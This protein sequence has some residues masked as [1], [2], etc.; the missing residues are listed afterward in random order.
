MKNFFDTIRRFFRRGEL[1][2]HRMVALV[3][4]A[5]LSGGFVLTSVAPVA[6]EP[7]TITIPTG[8]S[9]HE[10]GIILREAHVIRSAVLFSMLVGLSEHRTVKA[11]DYLFAR[12]ASV[13][14]VARRVSKGIFGV[15]AIRVTLPEG[16]TAAEMYDIL[17]KRLY[18]LDRETWLQATHGSEGMLFPDT[19]F[20]YPAATADHIVAMM[21]STFELKLKPLQDKIT[22][23]GRTLDDVI[24][25]ASL[26]EEEAVDPESRRLVAGILWKRLEAGMPL[27]VDAVFSYILGKNTFELSL[28]DLKVDSPYNTYTHRGLPPGPISNPGLDAIR[29]A[30]EPTPSPYWYYLTGNDGTM[31]YAK[32]FEEHKLNKKKYLTPVPSPR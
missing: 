17:A 19:Y 12:P 11:G 8:T 21:E 10:A 22:Q 7:T 6:F 20:I 9:V 30:L 24:T 5:L 14:T 2:D 3:V 4:A 29:A 31:H 25:M 26:I 18:G 32:T 15:A 16:T 1:P 23:S 27:Q 28:N 13:G